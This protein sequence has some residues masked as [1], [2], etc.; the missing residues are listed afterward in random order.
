MNVF[1]LF[2]SVV[3]ASILDT[4]VNKY[5]GALKGEEFTSDSRRYD[6][7]DSYPSVCRKVLDKHPE[8]RKI[9]LHEFNKFKNE[10]LKLK[11][12][13]FDITTSW[14]TQT[15]YG[16]YCHYHNHK[17]CYYSGVMYM[18]NHASGDL[19]FKNVLNNLHSMYVNPPEDWTPET[20]QTF[21]IRP[22][23]NL[24]VFFPSYLEHKIDLYTEQNTRYSLAFNLHPV[25]K[26]G[27]ADSYIEMKL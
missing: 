10:I 9:I 17:N 19:V 25:G 6:A 16:G 26:Y 21:Y 4:R 15:N 7:P 12:T 20:Y 24:V 3:G 13:D 11:S 23:Q 14:M 8:L 1:P 5:Y 2:P 22:L 27:E 18:D